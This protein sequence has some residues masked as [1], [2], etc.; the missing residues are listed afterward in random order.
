MEERIFKMDLEHN[1]LTE[2]PEDLRKL[3]YLNWISLKNNDLRTLPNIYYLC[4]YN[5][6]L[7]GN[8]NLPPTDQLNY[9]LLVVWNCIDVETFQKKVPDHRD[10]DKF[11]TERETYLSLDHQIFYY[12]YSNFLVE[13]EKN[14]DALFIADVNRCG[15][16]WPLE[17]IY[18]E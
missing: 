14:R 1:V 4:D 15:Q 16:D 17:E 13:F 3:P 12:Y 11:L 9:L 5:L 18:Y 8:P 7:D 10:F 6:A 2:F